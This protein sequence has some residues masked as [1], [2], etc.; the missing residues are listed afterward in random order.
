MENLATV[1]DTLRRAR[2]A[3]VNKNAYVRRV[4]IAP[5]MGPGIRMERFEALAMEPG[6][7]A[8]TV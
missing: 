8:T 3:G 5:T 6:K 2:P 1:M 4:T 7:I